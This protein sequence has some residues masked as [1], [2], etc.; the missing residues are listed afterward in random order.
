MNIS[1]C[2]GWFT[3]VVVTNNLTNSSICIANVKLQ[4]EYHV[5]CTSGVVIILSAA[6]SDLDREEYVMM[7]GSAAG[8]AAGVMESLTGPRDASVA[9]GGIGR[10]IPLTEAR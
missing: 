4:Q 8:M 5:H 9:L 3:S 1:S 7:V 6:I 10:A 2:M